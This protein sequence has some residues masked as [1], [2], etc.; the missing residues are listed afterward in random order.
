M[1]VVSV[2]FLLTETGASQFGELALL[3]ELKLLQYR[4]FQ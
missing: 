4:Y 3:I 1:Q 2:L